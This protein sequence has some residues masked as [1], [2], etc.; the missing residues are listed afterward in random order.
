MLCI[1]VGEQYCV[2][3]FPDPHLVFI[4]FRMYAVGISAINDCSI[5]I[6]KSLLIIYQ[7]YQKQKDPPKLA[8]RY[9]WNLVL[10]LTTYFRKAHFN[11]IVW[12]SCYCRWPYSE[13]ICHKNSSISI[14]ASNP[15]LVVK[16]LVEN[17]K[18][19]TK[20]GT[21]SVYL[22]LFY[23]KTWCKYSAQCFGAVGPG[24]EFGLGIIFPDWRIRNCLLGKYSNPQ[25]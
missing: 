8:L 1:L 23:R 11:T 4:L 13:R 18:Y 2:H 17:V 15:V 3:Y 14:P 21:L 16:S 25:I 24:S 5:R 22:Q 20:P 12:P 19:S 6:F 9:V 10:N 7:T